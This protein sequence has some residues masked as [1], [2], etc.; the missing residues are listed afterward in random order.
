MATPTT[1]YKPPDPLRITGSELADNWR[2]FRG[3]WEN[4]VIAND[5]S[6]ATS[7]KQA[8]VFLTC[9]GAE[10]YDVFRAMN[11]ESDDDRKKIAPIIAG[12]EAFCIGAV[13]VKRA[14]SI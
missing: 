5:L 14:L 13:N 3:Q 10:A 2:R 6:E 8:A 1:T 4:Y 11:F 7:E 9:I 12:F